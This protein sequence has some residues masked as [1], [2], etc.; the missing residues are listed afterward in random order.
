M[1]CVVDG[2]PVHSRWFEI[3]INVGL[4]MHLSPNLQDFRQ[5]FIDESLPSGHENFVAGILFLLF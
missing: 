3:W 4:V 1:H 2:F 5:S